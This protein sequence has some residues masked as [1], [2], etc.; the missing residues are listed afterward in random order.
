MKK[1][2]KKD[3]YIVLFSLFFF[4]I[5]LKNNTVSANDWSRILTTRAVVEKG[6]LA[7]DDYEKSID[8]TYVNGHYYSDKPIGFSLLAVPV[9]FVLHS[10]GINFESHP[11]L[12]YQV[13][14]FFT[15]CIS[16]SLLTLIFYKA[17][18]KFLKK[19]ASRTILTA[20]L[21]CSNILV[22]S[23]IFYSHVT[24]ALFLFSSFYLAFLA[25]E[26]RKSMFLSGLLSGMAFLMEYPAILVGLPIFFLAA[27]KKKTE[28][29]DFILGTIVP[30]ALFLLFNYLITGNMLDNAY[31]HTA[32]YEGSEWTEDYN[33][34]FFEGVGPTRI[35][36]ML[37]SQYHGLFFFSPVLLFS[38]VSLA[39]G[40]KSKEEYCSFFI[41]LFL[42]TFIFFLGYRT[43]Y[44]GAG[45]GNRY[46][47][48]I[49]PFTL[50]GSSFLLKKM[51]EGVSI[52]IFL[53]CLSL[54]ISLAGALTKPNYVAEIMVKKSFQPPLAEA[55]RRIS[56]GEVYLNLMSLAVF[57]VLL[58]KKKREVLKLLSD[59]G[60]EKKSLISSSIIIGILFIF[61]WSR[62]DM[63]P[64]INIFDIGIFQTETGLVFSSFWELFNPNQRGIETDYC[65]V[66]VKQGQQILF[67]SEK[68]YERYVLPSFHFITHQV[69]LNITA[70]QCRNGISMRIDC[71]CGKHHSALDSPV[72]KC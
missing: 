20:C 36:K 65:T 56:A 21:A 57:L 24:T 71:Y 69:A 15:T 42:S 3:V 34:S 63:V 7:I 19:E 6:T 50:L 37:F 11:S 68:D 2:L 72:V 14:T 61:S 49:I 28:S 38:V 17:T 58:I 45:Y 41:I 35:L 22:Y 40:S 10:I 44:G 26:T 29:I 12:A 62:M 66:S 13:V 33:K 4:T 27:I 8:A 60:K 30:L 23:T 43:F 59:I 1:R 70:D 31:F 55:L 25:K 54:F 32:D 51:K 9:Y 16:A 48:Q 5:F 47:I 52:I 53:V 39:M 18:K 67:A 64:I 46:F